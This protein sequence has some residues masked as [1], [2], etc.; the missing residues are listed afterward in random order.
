[1]RVCVQACVFTIWVFVP[2]VQIIIIH[3]NCRL[4]IMCSDGQLS[5][6][7]INLTVSWCFAVSGRLLCFSQTQ[8]SVTYR[9][10]STW[11]F[12]QNI[13]ESSCPVRIQLRHRVD[14]EMEAAYVSTSIR[15]RYPYHGRLIE[16]SLRGS[17]QTFPYVELV[18]R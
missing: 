14:I 11:S 17:T 5:L 15:W 10:R 9:H 4:W 16:H 2:S 7:Q 3:Q 8:V 12:G 13:T 6:C 18:S 1:M